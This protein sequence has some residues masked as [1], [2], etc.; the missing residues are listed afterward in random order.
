MS[1]SSC[2]ADAAAAVP[3][4]T[5][6]LRQRNGKLDG[7]PVRGGHRNSAFCSLPFRFGRQFAVFVESANESPTRNVDDAIF[8]FPV[9]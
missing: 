5:V 1:G 2:T 8:I 3:P 4:R 9:L 6:L 7:I